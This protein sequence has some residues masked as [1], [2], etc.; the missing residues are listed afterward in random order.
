MK[1]YLEYIKYIAAA[2]E[3]IAVAS[4]V[5]VPF[6]I[7]YARRISRKLDKIDEHLKNKES[8]LE[9]TEKDK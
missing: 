2:T 3:V 4:A 8:K 9:K 7:Y 5:G 6:M 1:H